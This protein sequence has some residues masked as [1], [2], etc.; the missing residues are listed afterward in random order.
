MEIQGRVVLSICI[1]KC[2]LQFWIYDQ[3]GIEI[4]WPN[5]EKYM[6]NKLNIRLDLVAQNCRFKNSPI[7]LKIDL[8]TA[9]EVWAANNIFCSRDAQII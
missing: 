2:W 9:T 6:T 8:H 1:Y 5:I 3:Y 7:C 4:I